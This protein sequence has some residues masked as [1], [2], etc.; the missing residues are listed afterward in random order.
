MVLPGRRRREEAGSSKSGEVRCARELRCC[1]GLEK[2]TEE[3]LLSCGLDRGKEEL[4]ASDGWWGMDPEG[5]LVG[6][7]TSSRGTWV[8]AAKGLDGSMGQ[9]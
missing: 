8:A 5:D 6:D 3:E 9:D 2:K 4:V 7:G 1:C